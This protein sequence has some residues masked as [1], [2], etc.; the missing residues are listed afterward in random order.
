[1]ITHFIHKEGGESTIRVK[2]INTKNGSMNS[3]VNMNGTKWELYKFEKVIPSIKIE[4]RRR[5]FVL[6]WGVSQK[7]TGITCQ[8]LAS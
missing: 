4:F 5:A 3:M 7:S 1:M 6:I 8:I 2:D